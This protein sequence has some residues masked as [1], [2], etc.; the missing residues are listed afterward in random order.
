MTKISSVAFS[1][2]GKSLT[3]GLSN[4]D[5]I[6]CTENGGHRSTQSERYLVCINWPVVALRGHTN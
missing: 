1:Q 2:D 5:I 6:I 3:Q 4:G